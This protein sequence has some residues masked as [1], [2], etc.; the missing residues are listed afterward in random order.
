MGYGAQPHGKNQP[1][2]FIA[3]LASNFYSMGVWGAAPCSLNALD[4]TA[5]FLDKP[6]EKRFWNP[7]EVFLT[8][9][10][11]QPHVHEMPLPLAALCTGEH[12]FLIQTGFR[13]RVRARQFLPRCQSGMLSAGARAGPP[14]SARTAN[15]GYNP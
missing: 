14:I 2:T 15:R 7:R 3:V 13:R 12:F 4:R 10:G 8:G 1:L 6:G 11:A 9:Y 5:D